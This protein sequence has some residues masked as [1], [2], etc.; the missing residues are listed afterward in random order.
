MSYVIWLRQMKKPWTSRRKRKICSY[1]RSGKTWAEKSSST[2]WDQMSSN[3]RRRQVMANGIQTKEPTSVRASSPQPHK[4]RKRSTV[5]GGILKGEEDGW[6]RSLKHQRHSSASNKSMR[7]KW[8]HLIT[9]ISLHL[10]L[11]HTICSHP[12]CKQLQRGEKKGQER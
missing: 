4:P 11:F 3:R 9:S 12:V 8:P 6:H 5:E 7:K 1:W 10:A 2:S